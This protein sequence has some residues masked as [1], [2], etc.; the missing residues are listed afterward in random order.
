VV[1]NEVHEE[2][3]GAGEEEFECG[4]LFY[5]EDDDAGDTETDQQE[6]TLI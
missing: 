3:W 5:A 4:E 2:E 1:G 6:S